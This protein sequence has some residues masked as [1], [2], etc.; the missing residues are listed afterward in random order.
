M[1]AAAC[2]GD[3]H[4]LL[5]YENSNPVVRSLMLNYHDSRSLKS[6]KTT[7]C[8][9]TSIIGLSLKDLRSQQSEA[10]ITP[11]QDRSRGSGKA[12]RLRGRQMR[13]R[14][15][16][17]SG[18]LLEGG[19]EPSSS[20]S[21]QLQSWSQDG[22]S[23]VQMTLT[24]GWITGARLHP[25]WCS[26]CSFLQHISVLRDRYPCSRRVIKA[27]MVQDTVNF[28]VHLKNFN[29]S[30]LRQLCKEL[31]SDIVH[32]V[33]KTGGKQVPASSRTGP[34]KSYGVPACVGHCPG[35]SAHERRLIKMQVIWA[36]LWVWWN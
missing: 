20:S 6:Y 5:L 19:L 18:G 8:T 11:L 23:S 12:L 9:S 26:L 22:I 14:K 33:S 36:H 21:R 2:P 32:T 27:G 24:H 16:L 1:H 28:P 15:S 35:L 13:S 29:L 25:C 4:R 10:A 34:W 3:I 7:V 30:Q 31:R 17:A